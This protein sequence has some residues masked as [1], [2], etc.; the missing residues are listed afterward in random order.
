MTT[1]SV[2]PLRK[3]H[4]RWADEVEFVD[5][6]IRQAHP[7]PRARPYHSDNQKMI[8]A[9]KYKDEERIDWPVLVDDLPGTV[10]QVYGGLADPTY[11]IDVDGRVSFYNMW[12]HAPTLHRAIDALMRSGGRGI[13]N[14]GIHHMPHMLPA[15]ADGWKGIRRGL[16][17]S[18]FD[19]MTAAPGMGSS[20]WLGHKLR[21]VLG[22]IA[23]RATPLSRMFKI[24]L[25]AGVALLAGAAIT[26]IIRR[27][28]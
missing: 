13:V 24:A 14:G 27:R 16:P 7:G 11:L 26:Q 22:P 9:H 23:L 4:A 18:F 6:I 8:D 15:M 19:L 1:G 3:L 10:H 5:V 25:A 20:L 12:T 21:P 2:E 28:R 17:Q